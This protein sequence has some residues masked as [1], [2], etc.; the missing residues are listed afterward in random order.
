MT[1][2]IHIISRITNDHFH[3]LQKTTVKMSWN[4]WAWTMYMLVYKHVEND[5]TA[6]H[7]LDMFRCRHYLQF[8]TFLNILLSNKSR[9]F[10]FNYVIF[11]QGRRQGK[12]LGGAKVTRGSRGQSPLVGVRGRSPLK[13]TLFWC[14]N[15][16]RSPYRAC[17][18]FRKAN[19]CTFDAWKYPIISNYVPFWNL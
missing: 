16:D 13:L 18:S 2:N 11:H 8:F 1:L 9:L 12:L 6:N 14:Y 5:N 19:F 3:F 10:I 17:I 15:R 7:W 4:L